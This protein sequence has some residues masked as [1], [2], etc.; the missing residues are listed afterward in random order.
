MQSAHDT[1]FDRL[2]LMPRMTECTSRGGVKIPFGLAMNEL[3]KSIIR[4]KRI[5]IIG[6]GG[7]A[8]I[9]SHCASHYPREKGLRINPLND[10]SALTATANDFGYEYSYSKQIDVHAEESDLVVAISSSGKSNNIINA[11]LTATNKKCDVITLSGFN[12]DNPLRSSG[13][14]NFWVPSKSYGL[15]ELTHMALLHAAFDT[16]EG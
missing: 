3:K 11:A 8:S 9:A 13:D 7:S 16:M 10:I 14:L 1:Y 5:Y 6:N 2:A 4:V 15:I 12:P